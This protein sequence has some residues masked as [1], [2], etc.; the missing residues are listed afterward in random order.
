MIKWCVRGIVVFFILVLS[1]SFVSA[2]HTCMISPSI[3]HPLLPDTDC[4]GFVDIEDNCPFI[5][6]PMQ[7]D[8]DKNGLGN[9][10]DLYIESI[11]TQ[12]ADFVYNGRAFNTIVTMYNYREHNI[13]NLKV[14]VFIPELGIE[15][16]RYIDNLEVCNAETIEFFLRAPMCVPKNDYKIF[17]EASFMNLW[18]EYEIIPGITSIKVVPDL[19]CRM[20]LENNETIGNTFIDVME[21]QDVY[22]G[23]EAVFPIHIANREFNDKEYIFSVTGIDDDW[24]YYRLE[25]GSL[26]IVPSQAER[27]MDLYVGAHNN[28]KVVP[29]ERVFVVTVQSGEEYQR[30]LLIANVKEAL[31]PDQSFLWMFSLRVLLIGGIIVLII[32]GVVLGIIKYMKSVKSAETVQYY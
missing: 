2:Q 19:Y 20:I 29:G 22:K 30:F 31:E 18:G 4:D 6:N 14:R 25:P 28:M 15:S 17:V 3:G 5:T 10:C 26:I 32:I 8:S 24:G 21:I 16:V 12:P 27:V 9:A 1:I 7:R 11:N 13:R 23:Q